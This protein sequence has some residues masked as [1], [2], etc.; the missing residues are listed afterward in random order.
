MER[1]EEVSPD[2][3]SS[4]V[5]VT[6]SIILAHTFRRMCSVSPP[7]SGQ[8]LILGPQTSFS[9]AS[10]RPHPKY[11]RFWYTVLSNSWS[12]TSPQQSKACAEVSTPPFAA[13]A[14]MERA[15]I[16][17]TAAIWPFPGLEPSRLGKLRVVCRMLNPLW[18]GVSPAPKQGPQNAV[19][20]TAP[21][22]ISSVTAPLVIR[23]ASTGW[24]EGYTASEKSPLPQFLPR[25]AW[26]ASMTLV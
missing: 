5:V 2:G 4:S 3:I 16:S 17:A 21:A 7:I 6:G 26:A 12:G 20:I 19:R 23:S 13:V 8:S 1:K 10:G 15:S 25:R 18:A 11:T 14:A 24:E 9:S 22:P